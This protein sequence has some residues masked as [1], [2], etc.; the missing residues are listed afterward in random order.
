MRTYR[1]A[2]VTRV[3]LGVQSTQVHVLAALGRTH[4]RA[5]V[6][7]AVDA[8]NDAEIPSF[9]L[10]VIA[11]AAGE[12]DADFDAHARRRARGTTRRT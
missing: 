6:S 12:T 1:A 10:D 5:N 7:R 11:G 3:S 9:N 8:I 2:G 4:D